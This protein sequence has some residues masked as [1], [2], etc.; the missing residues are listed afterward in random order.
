MAPAPSRGS[1]GSQAYLADRTSC[2]AQRQC[3]ARHPWWRGRGAAGRADRS[4]AGRATCTTA[5]G[6]A[7][8]HAAASWPRL[9]APSLFGGGCVVMSGRA[10]RRQGRRR[11]AGQPCRP[12]RAGR[13]PGADP[14][15]RGQ[16]QGVLASL[17]ERRARVVECPKITRVG[18]PDG[19]VRDEFRAAG[20]HGRRGRRCGPC[21]TR[22][23]RPARA[24]RRLR[25]LAADTDRRH[26]RSRG[27]QLLPG[28]G[29]GDQL[30]GGRPGDGGADRE[31]L[32][33]L[34][35]ALA[36]GVAPVLITSA[37]AKGVRLL[38]RVGGAPAASRADLAAESAC[39]R[40]RSTGCGS[41]CAAGPGGGRARADAVAEADAQVKG[42]GGAGLRAGVAI[43]SIVACR[44]VT[45]EART[46]RRAAALA[47]H[48]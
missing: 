43:G 29:R 25:Q 35:W 15:G 17:A 14:C 22:S 41:S 40:G 38:G 46:C 27:R 31:A 39:R 3:P 47:R 44:A 11:R 30:H 16:G 10:G 28:P 33:Q 20:R 23:A 5:G 36:S 21:S 42:E 26:R 45:L 4:P 19:F 8:L 32:E 34:R 9:H 7:E 2:E 13:G 48:A 1:A 37:L 18:G 12:T 24:L 6:A